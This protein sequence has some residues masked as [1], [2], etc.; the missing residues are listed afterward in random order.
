[1][2]ASTEVLRTPGM[3]LPS[4]ADP[5]LARLLEGAVLTT[6]T[7]A[8][9][10]GLSLVAGRHQATVAV[11]GAVGHL[12]VTGVVAGAAFVR[13]VREDVQAQ[14]V[15]VLTALATLGLLTAATHLAGP[16]L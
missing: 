10:V 13:H 5:D 14:W 15:G 1:M 11:A 8:G 16:A 7:S 4:V 12:A 9:V 3:S 2:S 6:A